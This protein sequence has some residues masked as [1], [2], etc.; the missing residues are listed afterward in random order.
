MRGVPPEYR[1]EQPYLYGK[2]KCAPCELFFSTGREH[3]VEMIQY[4]AKLS[5]AFR[6]DVGKDAPACELLLLLFVFLSK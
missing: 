2:K 5:R 3:V 1:V 4:C 6:T